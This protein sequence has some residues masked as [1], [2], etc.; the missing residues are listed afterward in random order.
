MARKQRQGA[1]SVV[2]YSKFV[3]LNKSNDPVA[4]SLGEEAIKLAVAQNVNL[5]RDMKPEVR[6][7]YS[8]WKSGSFSSLWGNKR[9]CFGVDGGNLVQ[10]AT[11]GYS[12]VL[13]MG[14]GETPMSFVDGKNGFVYY[15]NGVVMGKIGSAGAEALTGSSDQFKT[16][17]PVGSFV[18]FL[19]PR[20]LV[21]RGNVVY[22]SDPVNRD[23]FHREYGFVQFE[24]AVRMAAVVGVNLFV[25]DT[26]GTW[27]LRK[28]Q[29]GNL[30]VAMPMF[31][32]ERVLGY[33]A[34]LGNVWTS[35]YNVS[36]GK[37]VLPEAAAWLTRRGVCVGGEDGSIV[38]LTE[39][40]YDIP[41]IPVGGTISF[42]QVGDLNLLIS[43]F[44]STS[45]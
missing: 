20:V 24:S 32:M 13:R 21:V 9:Y 30:P 29:Q 8:L 2:R 22:F 34:V 16:T 5:S 35:L 14:V 10:L 45:A 11:D 33:P 38:N 3:G 25:S 1:D 31:K 28:I 44:K 26:T 37:G 43:L 18:S 17:L 39:D 12:R 27:F 7:G 36:V 41:E 6:D 42:R 4:Y 40:K 23:V 15:T 19:S